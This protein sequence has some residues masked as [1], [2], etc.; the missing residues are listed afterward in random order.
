M[1]RSELHID[2][3]GNVLTNAETGLLRWRQG[4]W[5]S[6]GKENGLVAAGGVT[7]I[8]HDRGHGTWLATRGRGLQHWL[9]YGNWENWTAQQG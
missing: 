4:R 1:R 7:A 5:E 2:D 9:G 3:S 6:Y 8:Q